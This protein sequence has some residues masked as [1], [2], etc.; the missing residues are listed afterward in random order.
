M[1]SC[2]HQPHCTSGCGDLLCFESYGSA[3]EAE[4]MLRQGYTEVA[5]KQGEHAHA[6]TS[7]FLRK[8]PSLEDSMSKPVCFFLAGSVLVSTQWTLI[9]SQ[10][11][12][13]GL[14][15][16]PQGSTMIFLDI[17][18]V[19]S[20]PTMCAG[21]NIKPIVNHK[22]GINQTNKTMCQYVYVYIHISSFWW[23]NQMLAN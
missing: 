21:P 1:L 22:N 17:S 4:Y 19:P 7:I 11:F 13:Q 5:V 16:N 14:S 20:L 18:S 12:P 10:D 23:L 9:I 2:N 3:Q 8:I 6:S 15:G